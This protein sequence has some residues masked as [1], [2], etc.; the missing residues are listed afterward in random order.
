MRPSPP[1][2]TLRLSPGYQRIYVGTGDHYFARAIRD[3][4][5]LGVQVVAVLGEGRPAADLYRSCQASIRL[6]PLPVATANATPT[7][8]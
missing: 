2:L 6:G 5:E 8:A 4:G 7:A 3:I 1:C